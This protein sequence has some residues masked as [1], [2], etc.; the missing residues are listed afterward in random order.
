M[1]TKSTR[2]V[3]RETSAF[4][5][6]RGLRPLIVTIVGSYLEV[7]A[8]GLR[9]RETLDLASLYGLAIR[10]R[11]AREAAERK[12]QRAAKRKAAR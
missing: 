5:R 2:P 8:K 11:L 6:D 3:T 10:Q 12:T 7:R 4:V 1:A 9:S